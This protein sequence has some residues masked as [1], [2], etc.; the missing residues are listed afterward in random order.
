[1][2]ADN[3]NKLHQDLSEVRRMLTSLLEAIENSADRLKNAKT[4]AVAKG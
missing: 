3:Y 4:A 2:N 1:M